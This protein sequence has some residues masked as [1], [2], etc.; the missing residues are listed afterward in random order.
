V[1]GE[2]HEKEYVLAATGHMEVHFNEAF[3]SFVRNTLL[4]PKFIQLLK[5]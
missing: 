2:A 4:D 1:K 5:Q 3:Q